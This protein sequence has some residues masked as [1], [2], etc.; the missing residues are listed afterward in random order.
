MSA[1]A[2]EDLLVDQHA[3]PRARE[4]RLEMR[5]RH[6]RLVEPLPDLPVARTA[7]SGWTLTAR[8]EAVAVSLVGLVMGSAAFT[9]VWAFLS[10]SNVPLG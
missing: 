2:M 10:I 7:P 6:L 8:G 1:L 5:P 4:G 3:H 9:I